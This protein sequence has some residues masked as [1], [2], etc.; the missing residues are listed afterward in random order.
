MPLWSDYYEVQSQ[1]TTSVN[2]S[3]KRSVKMHSQVLHYN[4]SFR[5]I[6]ECD[7]I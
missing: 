6:K 4:F 1:L 3:N 5:I 2:Y 7:A